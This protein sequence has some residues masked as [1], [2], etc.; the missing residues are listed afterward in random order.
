[1]KIVNTVVTRDDIERRFNER[2]DAELEHYAGKIA[3]RAFR[4]ALGDVLLVRR[5]DAEQVVEMVD[6]ID[7]GK[8]DARQ[9]L[10]LAPEGEQG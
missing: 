7:G 3:K 2:I 8:L 10:G 9:L 1:M 5:E 4:H 6:E